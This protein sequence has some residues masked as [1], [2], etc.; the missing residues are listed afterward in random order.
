MMRDDL[1]DSTELSP[2]TVAR[3]VST[4]VDAELVRLRPDMGRVGATGRPSIPLQL[5]AR[6]HAVIGVHLGRMRTTVAMS[7]VRGRVLGSA[8]LATPADLDGLACQ[9]ASAVSSLRCGGRLVSS[10]GL[11]GA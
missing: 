2:A 11:V 7:D 4:L 6:R 8:D 5:D 10:A 3:A 9:L 1:V